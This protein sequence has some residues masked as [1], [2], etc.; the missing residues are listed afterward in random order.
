[1]P[2]RYVVMPGDTLSELAERN[3]VTVES[4]IKYNPQFLTPWRNQDEI[5]PGEIIILPVEREDAMDTIISPRDR[6]LMHHDRAA[7]RNQYPGECT[8]CGARVQPGEGIVY[9]DARGKWQTRH[10]YADSA[11]NPQGCPCGT[12]HTSTRYIP[13]QECGLPVP[14]LY[15]GKS[16]I[17]DDCR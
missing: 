3:G 1:M 2:S 7:R 9:R 17:C 4:L 12:P 11:G 10:A 14:D 5:F 15:A 8:R 16:Y 6:Q 13:C